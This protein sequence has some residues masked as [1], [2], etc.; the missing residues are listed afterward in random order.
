M[1]F[2]FTVNA[3]KYLKSLNYARLKLNLATISPR[4]FCCCFV[5]FLCVCFNI[6]GYQD[7]NDSEAS[8]S[9]RRGGRGS[10]RGCRGG[11][12]LGSPS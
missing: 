4:F 10:F 11:F 1:A 12:G 7:G 8:G 2:L 3:L 5:L 6:I 9:S